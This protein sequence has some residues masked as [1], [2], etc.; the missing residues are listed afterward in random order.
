MNAATPTKN[1]ATPA[2]TDEPSDRLGLFRRNIQTYAIIL[3]L[4]LSGYFLRF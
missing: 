1:A 2:K 4:I 3:A